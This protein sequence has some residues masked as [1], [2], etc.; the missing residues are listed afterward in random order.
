[1]TKFVNILEGC[2]RR[3]GG[4]ANAL[5]AVLVAL[6][7]LPTW[8]CAEAAPSQ[9][10]APSEAEQ[11]NLQEIVVTAQRRS[12]NLQ[13]VP[14]AVSAITASGLEAVGAMTTQDLTVAVPGLNFNQNIG[15]GTP[16]IRGVGS[17]SNQPGNE[18]PVATYVDG[19]YIPASSATIFEFNNVERVEVLRGPQGTL[20]GRNSSGGVI[21]VITRTPSLSASHADLSAGYGN[22]NTIQA[23]AYL[24]TPLS[25]KAAVDLAITYH[26]QGDGY[27]RDVVTGSDAQNGHSLGVR[28]K[29]YAEPGTDTTVTFSAAYNRF[30]D[31]FGLAYLVYP[32]P[33]NVGFW[34]IAADTPPTDT[35]SSAVAALTATHSFDGVKLTSITSYQQDKYDFLTDVDALPLPLLNARVRADERFATQEL[36][37]SSDNTSSYSWTTGL[38]YFHANSRAHR[39]L[40][41]LGIDPTGSGAI[42]QNNGEQIAKSYAGYVQGTYKFTDNTALTAG[43]RFTEDKKLF[44]SN[45]ILPGD[46]LITPPPGFKNNDTASKLTW[47]LA[48]DH[49]FSDQA[50]VYVSFNRGFKSG[51]FNTSSL[52]DPPTRP[53]TLDALEVGSKLTF[54]NGDARVNFAAF[55]YNYK[56][57]QVLSLNGTGSLILQ[58]ASNAKIDGLEGEFELA[59]TK[60]L[61]FRTNFSWIPKADYKDYNNAQIGGGAPF[62]A[63]GNRMVH[64]PKF[65]GAIGADYRVPIANGSVTF[66][67]NFYYNSGWFA[68]VDDVLNQGSYG[69]INAS[70]TW[71]SSNEHFSIQ[72]WGKNLGNKQYLNDIVTVLFPITVAAAPRTYGLEVAVKY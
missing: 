19:V 31:S 38:Y 45:D 72:L 49:H 71:R 27:G 11:G 7:S 21:Q 15:Q 67:A 9:P 53:E 62:D 52:A 50:M 14:V 42:V 1:M 70:A 4:T 32:A 65:S 66:N 68:E 58:N 34:D 63:S 56:D 20:F 59:P 44:H 2:S 25:D 36:Q 55:H 23:N 41:G 35:H 46:I 43:L 30:V 26:N 17:Q 51:E 33:P 61:T 3:R 24:S 54:W 16:Y 64:T 29:L 37:L 69:L 40:T 57:L 28:S 47:R 5:S 22:L 13:D 60:A 8:V 12:E 6:F 18:S 10:A 48:L 39:D